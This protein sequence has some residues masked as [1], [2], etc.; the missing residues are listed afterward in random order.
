MEFL[1]TICQLSE[2]VFLPS[3]NQGWYS[4]HVWIWDAIGVDLVLLLFFFCAGFCLF[5]PICMKNFISMR[6][7]LLSAPWY[8]DAKVPKQVC[9]GAPYACS[10]D[11]EEDACYRD[12]DEEKSQSLCSES[13][14]CS[15]D[16]AVLHRDS[17][18]QTC[19]LG[20]R[21]KRQAPRRQ[22][23]SQPPKLS[24]GCTTVILRNLPKNCTP[25]SF[26]ACLHECGYFGQIDM[27]YVPI[28]FKHT[29]SNLGF[30]V[31]D[32]RSQSACFDFALDFHAKC[33]CDKFIDVDDRYLLEVTE[34]LIQGSQVNIHR[35]QQ[36]PI[37]HRLMRYRTWLPLKVDAGGLAMPI[38]ATLARKLS[39]R[40]RSK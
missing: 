20:H 4:L 40:R 23:N 15:G 6:S 12:S 1:T 14:Q 27:I 32:F 3:F 11:A 24:E 8:V 5:R 25:H 22:V 17:C 30:A 2:A 19:L 39:R 35:L 34:A 28:D 38:E 9:E 21:K 7:R 10:A 31:V 37:L 33:A 18:R 26:L 29:D 16:I 36:S 13:S